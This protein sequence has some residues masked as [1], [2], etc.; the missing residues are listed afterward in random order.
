M[1]SL[2]VELPPYTV[3]KKRGGAVAFY[4]QLPAKHRPEGWA[5]T[6]RLPLD[7]E[8]RTGLAD[9]IELAAV[10]KDGETLYK[11]LTG[12]KEGA[13]DIAGINT[14]PWL[15]KEFDQH[16]KTTPRERPISKKTF[17][18]YDYCARQVKRWSRASG[19]PHVKTISRPGGIEF[20][21]TMNATPTKRKHV[22]SYMR[23]L[24]FYAMDLGLRD[25]NPFI[26]MKTE[27]PKA[28]VHIWRDDELLAMV[29][30][31]DEL[32][33]TAVATAMLIAHDEGPRPCDILAFDRWRKPEMPQDEPNQKDLERGHY[34]PQDG[35][36]RYFQKKTDDWVV[37]PAGKRVRARLAPLAQLQRPLIMNANTLRHY[38][39]RVFQRDFT[40]VREACSLEHLQFR[41]LRHT[42][43][44]K[45]KRA[46]LDAFAIASKTGHSEKSVSEMLRNHYLPHDSEV[47]TAATAK[48]DAY[49]VKREKAASGKQKRLG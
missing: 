36:F 38:N 39:E 42:F 46:G 28:K 35:T 23:N 47:A 12:E 45:G 11:R 24:M 25:N 41:H 18:Q 9:A 8:K 16:L 6:Y 21:K 13:P 10:I 4:F 22:A 17:R 44:V 3:P 20:L 31:A 30:K 19:H 14:L 48:I 29:A 37:S 27:T 43:V 33:L 32:G 5:P 34:F 2:T 7:P 49:R 40:R 1:P 15:I 26:R